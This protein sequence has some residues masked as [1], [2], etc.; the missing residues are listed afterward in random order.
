MPLEIDVA[1]E[2]WPLKETFTISRGSKTTAH[3]VVVTVSDGH[4]SGHGE[5][6]PYARYGETVESVIAEI[7]RATPQVARRDDI[8]RAMMAGAARNAVDCAFW[9]LEAKQSGVSVAKQLGVDGAL[10]VI[11]AYTISLDAPERMAAK[12]KD[13][14]GM[15]LLKLKLG[16]DGDAQRMR[17]VRQAR[18]DARLIADANEA[19][20]DEQLEPFMGVA[21]ECAV[22]LI[23]QPLP[24]GDDEV[25]ASRPRSV[26]ICADESVHTAADLQRLAGRYD[27]VNVKL[28]KAGGLTEAINLVDAA[29][30][31]GM[32]IMIG[33]MVGTSLSVAPAMMLAAKADWTDLD[34]PLFLAR[35]RDPPLRYEGARVFLPSPLLWG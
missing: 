33:S 31:S 16:G 20:T 30:A 29:R 5:S 22:E 12:A 23:E 6:V 18:P 15:P 7:K 9:D 19:W 28:D 35:D 25:L 21:A 34:G 10:S 4:H 26:P 27:A 13:A 11:T 17:A 3:V 14:R 1:S 2:V 8:A 32:K 24:S